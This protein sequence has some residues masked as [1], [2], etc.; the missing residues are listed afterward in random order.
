VN[1][2]YVT[3]RYPPQG[4]GVE[5]HVRELAV[6]LVDRGHDV[7][8]VSADAGGDGHRRE[9]RDGVAV[10][11]VRAFAPGGNV[12]LAL[13]V[14]PAVRRR[15]GDMDVVHVHNYHSVPFALGAL[16]AGDAPVVATAHY[17][18]GS[19]SGLRDRLLSLYRPLGRAAVARADRLL[20]VSEWERRQLAAD[21]GRE[22]QVIP[23]GVVRERFRAASGDGGDGRAASADSAATDSG[24]PYLLC[25]GRLERYKGIQHA[26]DAL[27]HLDGYDL[28]VAGSGAYRDDLERRA[29]AADVADRVAFLGYVDDD[30]LPGLYAGA[31][32]HVTLSTHEAY[33]MTVAESLAA[34]TPVV[35]REARALADWTTE[36]GVVGVDGSKS[37]TDGDNGSAGHADPDPEA[38]AAAVRRAV[39]GPRPDPDAVPSWDEVTTRVADVY[40]DLVG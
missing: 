2:C 26:I 25:V 15:V 17:H 23:N 1:V 18:A 21:F 7:T 24:R 14:C 35:V 10:R 16:C 12:Y 4:G 13:G 11:R 8:V 20:A 38:V 30:R 22:A 27:V 40:A 9:R 34:G 37:P 32:A 31:A 33:G 5:T 39:D 28:L 19:D 6:R 36:R 3:H 29:R